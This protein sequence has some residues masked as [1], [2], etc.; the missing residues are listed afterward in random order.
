MLFVRSLFVGSFALIL[1][2]RVQVPGQDGKG[3]SV[4]PGVPQMQQL[5]MMQ[6][7]GANAVEAQCPGFK[8]LVRRLGGVDVNFLKD[9]KGVIPVPTPTPQLLRSRV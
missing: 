2:V 7:G 5:H 3:R 4:R 9:N 8:A 1:L 6:I